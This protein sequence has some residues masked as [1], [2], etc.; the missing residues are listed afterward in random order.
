MKIQ[1]FNKCVIAFSS[2]TLA[3]NLFAGIPKEVELSKAELQDKI[4]GGWAGQTIGVTYTKPS[5][6]K[7]NG[8]IIQPYV[9]FEWGEDIVNR[10]M[11][12]DDIYMDMTFMEVIEREGI[13]APAES[14]ALEMAHRDY[15]LWH[16]NQAARYNILNGIMPPASGNWRNNIHADCIDAQIEADFAGIMSP[17]MI[18]AATEITDTVSHIMNCGDSYYGAAYVAGMYSQAFV[19]DDI[20]FVLNEAL[21]VV[22]QKS[23]FHKSMKQV[24]KWCKLHPDWRDTWFEVQKSDWSQTMHCPQGVF[25]AFN[26]DAINNAAYIVIGLYYGEKDFFKTMEISMRCGLDSDCNPSNAAGILGTM[27]GYSN[28]PE[29]WLKP[30]QKFEDVDLRY[31]TTSMN[32]AYALSFKHAL[33]NIEKN[34]GEVRGDHVLIKYQK[35]E[36]LPY[37]VAFPDIYPVKRYEWKKDKKG[38]SIRTYGKPVKFT[39]TGFAISGVVWYNGIWNSKLEV[40]YVAEL[41]VYIDGKLDTIR[42]L[43]AAFHSRAT[44]ICLNLELPKGEHELHLKW[45][46]PVDEADIHLWEMIIYSDELLYYKHQ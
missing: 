7:F 19:S 32:R 18:N 2:I 12:N 25:E 9:Q 40:D 21:K 11:H 16:A 39:G 5:E 33:Q 17:G 4:K 34:G 15:N 23:Q 14:H 20:D 28:I 31:T 43:P 13:D 42:K 6:A 10:F 46:N 30:L 44:E 3:L 26:L 38:K 36:V 37:E 22:P 45:R 29:Y 35:P 8:T 1:V 27:I 24:I 41:E